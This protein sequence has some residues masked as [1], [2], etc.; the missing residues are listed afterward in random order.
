VCPSDSFF[1]FLT[2]L[3]R[4]VLPPLRALIEEKEPKPYP[5]FFHG[6]FCFHRSLERP[7]FPLFPPLPYGQRRKDSS[8]WTI[9]LFFFWR[10]GS[11]CRPAPLPQSG[12]Y[13]KRFFFFSYE[14]MPNKL[15]TRVF[16]PRWG[17][18]LVLF[19]HTP[20]SFGAVPH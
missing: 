15:A 6:F 11:E 2:V 1:P 20:D 3:P 9:N 12:G 13:W 8:A 17:V 16:S 10:P 7:L 5:P 19:W 14:W 4:T 18:V